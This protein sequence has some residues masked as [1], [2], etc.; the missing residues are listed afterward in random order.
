MNPDFQIE[1]SRDCN[2]NLVCTERL[3]LSYHAEF[4]P[5]KENM[6]QTNRAP[7][8]ALGLFGELLV[9]INVLLYVLSR[10]FNPWACKTYK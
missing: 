10:M 9:F 8:N 3:K 2:R 4:I 1:R 7:N 6:Q 5:H